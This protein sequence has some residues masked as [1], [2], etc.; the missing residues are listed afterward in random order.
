MSCGSVRIRDIGL[1]L[2]A[3]LLTAA[4]PG[5]AETDEGA[6]GTGLSLFPAQR[7]IVAP[8]LADPLE[9]QTRIRFGVQHH[10]PTLLDVTFGDNL[11][12]GRLEMAGDQAMDLSVRGLI[13]ARFAVNEESFPLQ[14]ADFVGGLAWGYQRGPDR[15]EAMLFHQSSHLGD[16]PLDFGDRD[17]IDFSRDSLR[18]LW[19]RRFGDLRVYLAPIVDLD[20]GPRDTNRRMRLQWGGEYYF[21]CLGQPCYA[22]ANAE[23]IEAN[24]WNVNVTGQVG[25][26]LTR[27]TDHPFAPRVFL[28]V[29]TG[30]SVYGQFWNESETNFTIGFGSSW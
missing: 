6:E 28:E 7:R 11:V 19:S 24:D 3:G 18:V 29:F 2:L 4:S 1:V 23:T 27:R 16:E 10:G 30:H 8:L 9:T 15:F 17:R 13:T 25:W 12:L 20:P 5:A 14:A 22:A 21:D 26:F